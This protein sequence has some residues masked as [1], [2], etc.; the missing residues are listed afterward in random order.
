MGMVQGRLFSSNILRSKAFSVVFP[1]LL[2]LLTV[3][4]Q[5]WRLTSQEICHDEPF[6][7]YHAQFDVHILA[8]QLKIYNNPPLFEMLLHFWIKVF[9]IEPLSVR[10]FPMIFASL[11][12]LALYMFAE[13]FFSRS[14]AVTGSLL[15][16]FSSL[17]LYYAHD[18]R[19]Y[20]LLV[21]LSILSMHFFLMIENRKVRADLPVVGFVIIN[22]LLIYAHYFGF[23]ILFFQAT[24]LLM[25]NR[26]RL[27]YFALLYIIVLILYIPHLIVFI[28]R[29]GVSVKNGTWIDPPAGVESLYN[30]LWSFCNE[31]LTTVSV[32]LLLLAALAALIVRRKPRTAN[33]AVVLVVI[34]FVIPF[35][36]MFFISYKVPMYI[37]RYLIFCIPAFYLLIAA[38]IDVLFTQ[39]RFNTI[40]RAIIVILFALTLKINPDKKHRI[41]EAAQ[42]IKE[43]KDPLTLVLVYPHDMVPGFAY[44]YNRE[45]FSETGD[46]KEYHLTDSL[47]AME[48]VY[49]IDNTENLPSNWLSYRKILFLAV[50]NQENG[51][52]LKARL[53]SHFGL[54][55]DKELYTS[56]H[57]LSYVKKE[58]D[59]K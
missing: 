54:M 2:L 34:W 24:F 53:L 31:P 30:M 46:G 39:R 41:A 18:C 14:V 32:I 58:Q 13:R 50:G 33:R 48:N 56:Q 42:L 1:C 44:Y 57:L 12:P 23:F 16:C 26:K 19:V 20:S 37:S 59:G 7:I 3:I 47:L 43:Q 15:L 36:G 9:G 49:V 10:L 8:D 21:L 25:Y 17:L 29:F 40:I 22:T 11:S 55:Q 52:R 4:L 35:F 38:C 6:S 5:G 27:L 51:D 45:S 28:S